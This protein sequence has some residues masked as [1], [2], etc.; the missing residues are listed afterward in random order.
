MEE[1]PIF[2]LVLGAGPPPPADVPAAVEPQYQRSY[3][4]HPEGVFIVPDRCLYR[5]LNHAFIMRPTAWNRAKPIHNCFT[6]SGVLKGRELH[7]DSIVVL[8][9]NSEHYTGHV[10][11]RVLWCIRVSVVG[12]STAF[13]YGFGENF[14]WPLSS[15]VC[16]K[17]LAKLQAMGSNAAQQ[18]AIE[19]APTGTD[20]LPSDWPDLYPVR[21]FPD[22][23][24]LMFAMSVRPCRRSIAAAGENAPKIRARIGMTATPNAPT[25]RWLELPDDLSNKVLKIAGTQYAS[26]EMKGDWNTF[27]AMRAVCKTWR[28][29][30]DGVAVKYVKSI[31]D[32][33]KR[34]L[35]LRTTEAVFA[36]RDA[37]LA[38]RLS[39]ISFVC[40]V[41]HL[42][43]FNLM[44]LRGLRAPGELPPGKEQ[45]FPSRTA[46]MD[47]K[48]VGMAAVSPGGKRKCLS[49]L[50]CGGA[51]NEA[52]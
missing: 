5:D 38:A 18:L 35:K 23:Y 33:V 40:D 21:E 14:L 20:F 51:T 13:R 17:I 41:Q 28:I 2:D 27:L 47:R 1:A 4:M 50:N 31:L 24:D 11:K 26:F 44:R 29:E 37:V 34:G 16:S 9:N 10:P 8:H 46:T 7:L 43:V 12:G 6:G 30:V 45:D 25:F 49:P 3:I 22:Y 32:I 48:R 15:S 19:W 36:A 52:R 39:S 42:S